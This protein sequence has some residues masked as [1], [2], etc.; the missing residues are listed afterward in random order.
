MEL[1]AQI[2]VLTEANNTLKLTKD[3]EQLIANT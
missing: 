2:S 1:Q 3:A